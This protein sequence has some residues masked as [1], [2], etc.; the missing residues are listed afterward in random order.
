MVF[1]KNKLIYL[2]DNYSSYLDHIPF[3]L[4]GLVKE[5]DF[6]KFENLQELYCSLENG[7]DKNRL[8]LVLLANNFP[9]HPTGLD[10]VQK[11]SRKYCNVPFILISR[12][13][14]IR[15]AAYMKGAYDFFCKYPFDNDLFV[16]TVVKGLEENKNRLNFK[17]GF[18]V[19]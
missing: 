2:A 12:D 6:K 14:E 19:S 13:P 11:Y 18:F 16:Q 15:E 7:R 5:Y 17:K 10:I 1:D 3:L 8:S 9:I 4:E